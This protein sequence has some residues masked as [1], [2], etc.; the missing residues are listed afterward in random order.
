MEK[1]GKVKSIKKFNNFKINVGTVDKTEPKT[2]YF[3]IISWV[4]PI[5][6]KTGNYQFEI[7]NLSKRIK[8]KLYSKIDK[9]TFTDYMVDL[10]LRSSGVKYGKY[11]Y[12]SCEVTLFNNSGNLSDKY[13]FD[14]DIVNIVEEVINDVFNKCKLFKYNKSKKLF[15]NFTD[16]H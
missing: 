12:M 6:D 16:K 14:D 7:K 1:K 11:S 4:T 8:N 9:G 3:E 5:N 13:M 2:R 10:D 15:T